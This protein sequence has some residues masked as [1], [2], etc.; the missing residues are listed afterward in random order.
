MSKEPCIP[1]SK[2]EA[3]IKELEEYAAWDID[4]SCDL[5]IEKFRDLLPNK[6]EKE[7]PK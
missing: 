7:K 3:K 5:I 4:P 2:I 6:E 1:I